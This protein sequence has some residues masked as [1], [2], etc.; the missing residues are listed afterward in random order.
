MVRPCSWDARTCASCER[1]KSQLELIS[2]LVKDI[3]DCRQPQK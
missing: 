2:T 3:R 1:N